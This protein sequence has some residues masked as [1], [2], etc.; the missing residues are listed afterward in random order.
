MMSNPQHIYN[1]HLTLL[2]NITGLGTR[3]GSWVWVRGV[4]VGVAK[5]RPSTNPYPQDGLTGFRGFFHG[6]SHSY[7]FTKN[8][9]IP[10]D[11]DFH[12]ECN[13]FIF[14]KNG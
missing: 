5:L 14:M 3:D 10:I 2:G 13:D 1:T 11:P 7:F 8:N 4:R 6:F 12:S 9:D